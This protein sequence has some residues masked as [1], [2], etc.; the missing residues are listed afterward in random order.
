LLDRL[1]QARRVRH[2]SQR[3]EERYVEWAARYIRFHGLRHPQQMGSAEFTGFLSHLAV[4]QRVVASSQKQLAA[5][6]SSRQKGAIDVTRFKK[7]SRCFNWLTN[8]PLCL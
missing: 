5:A 1:R 7:I 6:R 8:S 4:G 3:T 2:D